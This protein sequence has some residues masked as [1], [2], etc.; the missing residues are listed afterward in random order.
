MFTPERKNTNKRVLNCFLECPTSFATRPRFIWAVRLPLDIV[1]RVFPPLNAFKKSLHKTALFWWISEV[2]N[3]ANWQ[4]R[5]EQGDE[6]QLLCWSTFLFLGI[7]PIA[8][9]HLRPARLNVWFF[10]SKPLIKKSIR[11]PSKDWLNPRV[12]DDAQCRLLIIS[13]LS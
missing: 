13:V 10:S 12:L 4:I 2:L 11:T 3:R 1:L 8:V 5:A 7:S 6:S 9:K